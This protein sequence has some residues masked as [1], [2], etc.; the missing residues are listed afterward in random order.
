MAGN[1]H[2]TPAQILAK[3]AGTTRWSATPSEARRQALDLI[4]DTFAVIAAGARHPSLRPAAE[5]LKDRDGAA[6]VVGYSTGASAS[7]AALLNGAIAA[8]NPR[9]VRKELK[10]WR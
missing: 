8:L 2:P 7:N 10:N 6:T 9:Q 3:A 1:G 5:R 4:I